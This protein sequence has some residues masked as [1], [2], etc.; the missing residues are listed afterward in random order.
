METSANDSATDRRIENRSSLYLAASLY[1]DGCANPVKIRN[2]SS[3]GALLESSATFEPGSLVQLVRGPL[4]VHALV[5]WTDDGKLGLNFSGS[6]DVEHWR[7]T[8]NNPEQQR[9]DDIVRLVKAGAIPLPIGAATCDKRL[10]LGGPSPDLERA[11]ILLRRLGDRLARD[12]IVVASYPGELQNLDIAIQVIDAVACLLA[13]RD[14]LS[15]DATK[16][17]SLRKSAD[18]ALSRAI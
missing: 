11:S 16:F 12:C 3:T 9:V 4:I 7:K 2:I 13:S 10:E 8:V 5:A 1:C 6:I 15:I 18:Q 17:A 14:D